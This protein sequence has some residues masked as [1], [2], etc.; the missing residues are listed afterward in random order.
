MMLT[1]RRPE[2]WGDAR[3][4]GAYTVARRVPLG[5]TVEVERP[6]RWGIYRQRDGWW[7]RLSLGFLHMAWVWRLPRW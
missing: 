4:E 6:W 1:V 5:V 2:W 7:A 3:A